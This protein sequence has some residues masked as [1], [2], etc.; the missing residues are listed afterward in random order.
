MLT[1]KQQGLFKSLGFDVAQEKEIRQ[2]HKTC[3]KDFGATKD[4]T[5]WLTKVLH[6]R[7]ESERRTSV[8]L[9]D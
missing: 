8:Y 3:V 4:F 5:T 2:R 1:T 9:G 7:W 6:K